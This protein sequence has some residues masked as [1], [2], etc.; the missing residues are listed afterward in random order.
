[1][2]PLPLFK[3]HHDT[4]AT[5]NRHG[6]TAAVIHGTSF[7]RDRKRKVYRIKKRALPRAQKKKNLKCQP[8]PDFRFFLGEGRCYIYVLFQCPALSIAPT[9]TSTSK[10]VSSCCKIISSIHYFLTLLRCGNEREIRTILIWLLPFTSRRQG[11][12]AKHSER[13]LARQTEH[14]ATPSQPRTYRWQQSL[15]HRISLCMMQPQYTS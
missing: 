6:L 15:I 11:N 13:R 10:Y 2:A 4:T 1:M 9:G 12:R 3:R 5:S 14:G 7:V 8:E